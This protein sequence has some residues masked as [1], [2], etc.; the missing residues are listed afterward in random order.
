MTNYVSSPLGYATIISILG[1]G[2]SGQ[3]RKEILQAL[4]LPENLQDSEIDFYHFKINA[5]ISIYSS[6]YFPH[7]AH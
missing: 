6:Q 3:T 7:Y 5:I 2:S 4:E 1:H